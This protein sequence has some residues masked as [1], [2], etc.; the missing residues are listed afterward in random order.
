M[1]NALFDK[2]L[3]DDRARALFRQMLFSLAGIAPRQ[4]TKELRATPSRMAS[5]KEPAVVSSLPEF[6]SRAAPASRNR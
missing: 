4:G 5:R 3:R 6:S 2:K 1:H